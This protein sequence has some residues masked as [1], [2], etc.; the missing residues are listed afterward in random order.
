MALISETAPLIRHFGL[1]QYETKP[2]KDYRYGG[3]LLAKSGPGGEAVCNA[4]KEV[5]D[6]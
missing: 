1:W 4:L 6:R 3:L 2:F 5:F